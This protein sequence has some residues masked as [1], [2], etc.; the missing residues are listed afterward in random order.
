[1]NNVIIRKFTLLNKIMATEPK[2]YR[3]KC[4]T[5]F[6][7]TW[8]AFSYFNPSFYPK[9]EVDNSVIFSFKVSALKKQISGAGRLC[10]S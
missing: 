2:C 9:N 1:M 7:Q 8:R 5:C 10:S 6:I 3:L 4:Y